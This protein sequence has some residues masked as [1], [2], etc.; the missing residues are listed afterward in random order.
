MSAGWPRSGDA[1][2]GGL[3][4][5][6]LNGSGHRFWYVSLL[7]EAAAEQGLAVRLTVTPKALQTPAWSEHIEPSLHH[8]G[9]EVRVTDESRREIVR[10]AM[11]ENRR[12]V[13]PDGDRWAG[14]L[15]GM[16]LV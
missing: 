13:V 6:E 9:V 8:S 15:L 7:L 16:A 4:I 11:A 14:V 3:E 2:P 5:V 10:Q 12:L 1:Q